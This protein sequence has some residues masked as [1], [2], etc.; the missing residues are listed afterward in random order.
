VAQWQQTYHQQAE[1]HDSLANTTTSDADRAWHVVLALL[2]RLLCGFVIAIVI[3]YA[4]HRILDAT[5]PPGASFLIQRLA[6]V[7]ELT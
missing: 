1:C 7:P 6:Y 2:W 5:R 3:G 4:S